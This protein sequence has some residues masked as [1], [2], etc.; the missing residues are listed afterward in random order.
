MRVFKPQWH[1]ATV[2]S[3]QKHRNGTRVTTTVVNKFRM[4]QLVDAA[5][6]GA[7]TSTGCCR[8]LYVLTEAIWHNKHNKLRLHAHKYR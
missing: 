6:N 5:S 7:T 2:C 4:H 3:R 1:I 8:W